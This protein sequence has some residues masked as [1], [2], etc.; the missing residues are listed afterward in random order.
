MKEEMISILVNFETNSDHIEQ[1]HNLLE[2]ICKVARDEYKCP[3]FEI[4]QNTYANEKFFLME[5]WQNQK[6]WDKYINSAEFNSAMEEI[7]KIIEYPI[8]ITMLNKLS[9]A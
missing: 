8:Q 7:N 4:F 1:L 5:T 2:I 9:Q 6:T 3:R